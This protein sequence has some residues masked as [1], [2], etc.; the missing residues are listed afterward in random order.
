MAREQVEGNT[1]QCFNITCDKSSNG[2]CS[3][4]KCTTC[5]SCCDPNCKRCKD[6]CK[7][8]D[9]CRCHIPRCGCQ[10]DCYG[11][12]K[13]GKCKGKE[14]NDCKRCETKCEKGQPC[15]CYQC[16]CGTKCNGVI[17]SCCS[18]CDPRNCNGKGCNGYVIGRCGDK[19]PR[20]DK[21]QGHVKYDNYDDKYGAVL[22]RTTKNVIVCDKMPHPGE[23]CT[24]NNCNWLGGVLQPD[25][26]CIIYCTYCGKLCGQDKFRR[27]CYIAVPL[28]ITVSAFLIF[29]FMLPEKFHA[30]TTK[31]RAAF[32]SAPRHPG[33][34]LTN[35]VG[36][37]LPDVNVDRYA[38]F[39]PRTYAGLS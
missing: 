33:R 12:G 19:K 9:P 7:K 17:C 27:C 32:P 35:L 25:G 15:L 13:D 16:S 10:E 4:E 5:K 23:E 18:W 29:R 11:D 20:P 22:V 28:V 3:D 26:N 39:R 14:K 30:I 34:S 1:C 6:K 37:G 38:A 36:G 2:P 24:E 21:C 31:I 8:N